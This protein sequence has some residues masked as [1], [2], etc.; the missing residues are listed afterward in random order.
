MVLAA[1]ESAM[2]VIVPTGE[3]TVP[4][5]GSTKTR[6][7]RLACLS[8]P[9]SVPEFTQALTLPSEHQNRNGQCLGSKLCGKSLQNDCKRR[10]FNKAYQ[11]FIRIFISYVFEN[12]HITKQTFTGLEIEIMSKDHCVGWKKHYFHLK[13]HMNQ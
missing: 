13:L 7:E 11:R 1:A 6:S 10:H 12:C 2:A 4:H 9:E 3:R 5:G 8:S